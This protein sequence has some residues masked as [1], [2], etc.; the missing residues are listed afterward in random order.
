M[1]NLEFSQARRCVMYCSTEHRSSFPP[2]HSVLC[3]CVCGSNKSWGKFRDTGRS[4]LQW[5]PGMLQGHLSPGRCNLP[6]HHL[7]EITR[8]RSYLKVVTSSL[9]TIV[10]ASYSLCKSLLFSL[11]THILKSLLLYR[12]SAGKQQTK[13]TQQER[14]GISF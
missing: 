5:P 3:V 10:H 1:Q 4:L 2:N 8:G 13:P 9:P 12:K 7:D 6:S 11:I 14:V